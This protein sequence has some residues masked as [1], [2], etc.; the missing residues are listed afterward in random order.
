MLYSINGKIEEIT[1]SYIVINNND[2]SYKVL[3]PEKDYSYYKKIKENEENVKVFTILNIKET[4]LELIGFSSLIDKNIY[5]SLN[6]VSGIGPKAALSILSSLSIEEIIFAIKN[7][8][9]NVLT[10]VKGIGKKAANR[11]ILEV[12][13]DETILN[14]INTDNLN[15]QEKLSFES[16][17]VKNALDA[18]EQLGFKK[19]IVKQCLTK[20]DLSLTTEE[21][22]KLCL[23]KL[24]KL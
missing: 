23:K 5:Q 14:S 7:K 16:Q 21:L 17:N 8:N 6:N 3:I 15:V 4:T 10:R 22:I 18:L 24:N 2:I 19:T 13:V 20:E 9:E 11:I 1:Y 12:K